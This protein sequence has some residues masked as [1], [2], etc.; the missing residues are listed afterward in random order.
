MRHRRLI[1]TAAAAAIAAGTLVACSADAGD[2]TVTLTVWHNSQDP[3]AVLDSYAA[4]EEATGNKLELVSISSDGFEDATLTKWATGD[5]PDILEF[6]GTESFISLLNPTE[7]LQDLSDEAFVAASGSI[8]DIGGRGT[9]GKVYAAITNFPEVWGLYYSKDVLDQFGLEPAGTYAELVEQCEVLSAAGVPT[10]AEAGASV[11]PPIAMNALLAAEGSTTSWV[12]SIL[13]RSATLDDADSPWLEAFTDYKSLLDSGCMNSDVTSATFENA[14]ASV[15]NGEA[16]YQS[17]H[18]NIAPVYL[19]AA[20][21]D[22]EL[23][24]EKVGFTAFGKTEK[25]AMLNPGPI[26]TY[27]LPKT[28]DDAR[29]TAARGFLEFI[30]GEHYQAYIDESGTFPIIDGASD[31]AATTPLLLDIKAAYDG[32]STAL[33]AARLPSGLGGIFPLLSELTVGQKTP[34]EVAAALQQQIAD[35]ATAQGL[36][37]W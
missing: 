19:D 12:Q 9:D 34:E 13:D 1:A 8:Y 32:P 7:N 25:V 23:L 33:G 37:G 14:V 11:W 31:P 6:H 30:T 27:L 28:G 36:P 10:L 4:Y 21:G 20:G 2:G 5:R 15:Y 18:S 3:Q 29:E 22:A 17:I 35:A 24:G 16:A 26:G